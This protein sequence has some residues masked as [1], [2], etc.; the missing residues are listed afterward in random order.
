MKRAE[1]AAKR[2]NTRSMIDRLEEY[3]ASHDMQMPEEFLLCVMNGVDP[4]PDGSGDPIEAKESISAAKALM[5]YLYARKQDVKVTGEVG[6]FPVPRVD[7]DPEE[8][9]I[10]IQ[11]L[12][13]I[14]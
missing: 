4:R 14:V 8:A 11:K 13:D 9:E 12:S 1:L 10:I 2:N 5:P 7:A 6:V 3:C